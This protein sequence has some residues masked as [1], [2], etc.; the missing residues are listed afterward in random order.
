MFTKSMAKD[1]KL[2]LVEWLAE[3][4]GGAEF[5]AKKQQRY[6][7][8]G[9]VTTWL[10]EAFNPKGR[11]SRVTVKEFTIEESAHQYVFFLRTH[12]EEAV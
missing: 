7:G 4:G 8:N 12:Y 5:T 9:V 1:K 6:N 11:P 10:V 2:T 3:F